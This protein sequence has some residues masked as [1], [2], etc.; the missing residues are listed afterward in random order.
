MNLYSVFEWIT[1]ALG[2]VGICIGQYEMAMLVFLVSGQLRIEERLDAL[3]KRERNDFS[4]ILYSL[5]S[6]CEE[7]DMADRIKKEIKKEERHK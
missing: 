5:L 6:L 4:M 1:I 2:I 7:T 3:A